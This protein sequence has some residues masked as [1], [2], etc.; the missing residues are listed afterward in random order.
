MKFNNKHKSPNFNNRKKGS[1]IKYIVI[2]YTAMDSDIKSLQYL[3]DKKNRVS[4]H[5]LINKSGKIFQLVN[6]KFRAW[7]AG[8]SFWKGQRDINSNS[9]GIELDYYGSNIENEFY[10]KIQMF[11]LG[12]LLN[13]LKKKHSIESNNILGHSDIAPYRK[14]DPGKKFP[15]KTFYNLKLCYFPNK[16]SSKN[17]KKLK[18]FFKKKSLNSNSNQALYML[19]LIGYDV[20]NARKSKKNFKVLIKAYQAHYRN[21]LVDGLLDNE[22]YNLMLDHS[23]ESLTN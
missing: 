8:I 1:I 7:H 13:F 2:H 3:C 6:L 14:I 22:T 5:F 17:I 19:S 23:K 12:K 21:S 10:P 4:S 15:W 11:Y 9:I 16:L 20:E 18:F